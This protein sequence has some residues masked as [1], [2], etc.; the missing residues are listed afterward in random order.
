MKEMHRHMMEK[1]RQAKGGMKGQMT[2]P[3]MEQMGHEQPATEDNR[4][5]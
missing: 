2:C 4:D 5:Q 3:L 1:M